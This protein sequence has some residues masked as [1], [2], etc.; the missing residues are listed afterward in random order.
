MIL[1]AALRHASGRAPVRSFLGRQKGLLLFSPP[2]AEGRQASGQKSFPYNFRTVDDDDRHPQTR[3][4]G[5]H[6]LKILRPFSH[7]EDLVGIEQRVEVAELV[8][9]RKSVA[10]SRA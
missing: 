10:A 8:G 2:K 3:A 1:Q 4:S 6:M 9:P 7:H 5:F